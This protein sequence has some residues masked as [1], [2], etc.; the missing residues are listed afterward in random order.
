MKD[1]ISMLY[2]DNNNINER[3]VNIKLRLTQTNNKS[4]NE[5]KINKMKY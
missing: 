5:Q 1:I 2:N 3:F 4:K